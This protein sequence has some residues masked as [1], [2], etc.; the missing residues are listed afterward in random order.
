MALCDGCMLTFE[1]IS[2]FVSNIIKKA[3][4]LLEADA[5]FCASLFA[6]LFPS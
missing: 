4:F 3:S 2:L 5:H 1:E 6:T